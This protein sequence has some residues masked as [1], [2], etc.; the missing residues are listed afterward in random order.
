MKKSIFKFLMFMMI[1]GAVFIACEKSSDE[2]PAE[3]NQE[4]DSTPTEDAVLPTVES[5]ESR[6]VA[7][8]QKNGHDF[9][10]IAVGD[11]DDM[12]ITEELYGGAEKKKEDSKM[13]KE[14]KQTPFDIFIRITQENVAVPDRIAITA[15]ESTLRAS[16]RKIMKTGSSVKIMDTN[17][18]VSSQKWG[19]SVGYN[20]FQTTYCQSPVTS[21]P[22]NIEFCNPERR[23][24]LIK[25][26]IFGGQW[27]N[28]DDIYTVVNNIGNQ[29]RV[30]FYASRWNL[31]EGTHWELDKS[32]YINSSIG[33][34]T[35]YSSEYTRRRVRINGISGARFRAFIRFH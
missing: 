21:T 29:T 4:M 19:T 6:E 9:T 14:Q 1:L 24:L 7:R 35:Y 28:I 26:S 11:K 16:G 15:D 12:V 23:T 25:S 13:N 17:Y 30:R 22:T 32:V 5:K 20:T 8:I 10:F 18:T 33:F 3:Q 31:F 2:L 27:K 34:A